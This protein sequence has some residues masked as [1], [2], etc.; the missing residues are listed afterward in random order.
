M[1]SEYKKAIE[2]HKLSLS[3]RIQNYGEDDVD[4]VISYYQLGQ[5]YYMDSKYDL[6][7][8]N[9]TK[10]LK[11]QQELNEDDDHNEGVAAISFDLA[12]DYYYDSQYDKAIPCLENSLE[13]RRYIHGD[14]D[15]SVA[16]VYHYLGLVYQQKTCH[17]KALENFT[18]AKD[19]YTELEGENSENAL[20]MENLVIDS[21]AEIARLANPEII[22][23]PIN[24][25]KVNNKK[26]SIKDDIDEILSSGDTCNQAEDFSEALNHYGQASELCQKMDDGDEKT[27][28]LAAINFKLGITSKNLEDYIDAEEFLKK[29]IDGFLSLHGKDH[30]DTARSYSQ[31]GD[32]KYHQDLYEDAITYH[33]KALY[34]YSS[35]DEKVLMAWSH[36][37]LGLDYY[38][39]EQ[40]QQ[41]I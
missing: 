35:I 37:D 32:V 38:W 2:N 5:D 9:H 19:V 40:Y 3:I 31:L 23:T 41:S 25:Q 13:I 34:S 30:F 39:M 29:S 36:Y 28:T 6:A 20:T 7:I 17:K 27:E 11:L 22:N 4:V 10:A 14:V 33:E 8:T 18:S 15:V 12:K 1:N 16:E 21:N 24:T 26:E